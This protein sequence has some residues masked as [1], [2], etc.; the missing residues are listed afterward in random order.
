MVAP[1]L[2]TVVVL[3]FAANRLHT[4]AWAVLRANSGQITFFSSP[5]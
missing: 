2:I 4:I 5:R 3:A 1:H